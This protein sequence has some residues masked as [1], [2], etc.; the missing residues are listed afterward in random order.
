MLPNLQEF[1]LH[2]ECNDTYA[3]FLQPFVL[4]VLRMLKISAGYTSGRNSL[5]LAFT[6][7]SVRLWFNLEVFIFN[8]VAISPTD[9]TSILTNMPS[10]VELNLDWTDVI[11]ANCL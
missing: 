6:S 4:T 5:A 7:L 11:L 1:S 3:P 10:L 9:V 8:G 2:V